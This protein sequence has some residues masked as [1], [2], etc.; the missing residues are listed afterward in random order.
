MAAEPKST[1]VKLESVIAVPGFLIVV[2]LALYAPALLAYQGYLWLRSG[3][4]ISLPASILFE[5]EKAVGLHWF[6]LSHELSQ[7][8][9]RSLIIA[10][11]DLL[12]VVPD[13]WFAS[14]WL[15][16]PTSWI[17]AHKLVRVLL[18]FISVPFLTLCTAL[19][20]L[21]ALVR[22]LPSEN[23]AAR[24]ASLDDD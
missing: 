18:D 10:I 22:W 14:Q 13:S 4:W 6:G 17:G 20:L 24:A 3:F 8:Q 5:D 19:A 21:I 23:E 2:G 9:F 12:Q 15:S 7:S 1:P 11:Q 16:R